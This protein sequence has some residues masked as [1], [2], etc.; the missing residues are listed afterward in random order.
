MKKV[1]KI[2]TYILLL[3]LILAIGTL[4]FFNHQYNKANKEW[5][6]AQNNLSDNGEP[7]FQFQFNKEAESDLSILPLPKQLYILFVVNKVF[8]CLVVYLLI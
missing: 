7:F 5:Q 2:T 1:F 8:N 6:E 3:L 4:G